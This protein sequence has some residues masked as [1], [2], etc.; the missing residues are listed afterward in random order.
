MKLKSALLLMITLVAGCAHY[1]PGPSGGVSNQ[2]SISCNAT[3]QNQPGC[4]PPST[5][6]RLFN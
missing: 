4:H 2:S 1:S 3:P 5:K 6:Y